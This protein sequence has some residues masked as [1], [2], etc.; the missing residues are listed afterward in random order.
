MVISLLVLFAP[1]GTPAGSTVSRT[2]AAAV[3]AGDTSLLTEPR[4]GMGPIYSLMRSAQHQLDMTMYEL[5][6]DEAVSI[7]ESDAARGVVV[8]VLLDRAYAGGAENESAARN[9][10]AHGVK[11]HWAYDGAI[12]HQK[13]ITADEHTS[14]I[15]TLNLTRRYYATTRD[16]AVITTDRADVAAIVHV[17]DSD[18]AADR[19]PVST[20]AGPNLVWSPGAE[21]A[22]VR[23]IESARRSLLVE[24]EEMDD[25]AIESALSAAARRGVRVDV[26]MTSDSSDLAE[27]GQLAAAGVHV[28]TYPESA[29]LYIHAKVIVADGERAFVGSENFSVSSLDDNRELGIVLRARVLVASLS[30]TILHDFSGASP[31]HRPATGSTGKAWCR[32]TAASANDGYAGDFDVF[33][34]SNQPDR[35]AT[36]SDAGD[37]WS[38]D[39][40]GSGYAEIR[41]WHT[42][43][44]ERIRVVVGAATCSTL[45]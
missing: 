17:F 7:L 14:A 30:S 45:A 9:L 2:S 23:I 44:G 43:A 34:H 36:A 12:F 15:M 28:R 11:V 33:V 39:T 22:L 6:D 41:L 27:L 16:F 37:S 20:E 38:H 8:R 4:D 19:P 42:H 26:V 25:G 18:W 40:N 32:A 10:A 13:T 5:S 3:K 24:N 31:F 29:S 35:K 1:S 21:P